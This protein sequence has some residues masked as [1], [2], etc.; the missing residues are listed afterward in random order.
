LLLFSS[1]HFVFKSPIQDRKHYSNI[2]NIVL[3]ILYECDTWSSN[4][5]EGHR[6]SVCE[7]RVQRG[8]FAPNRDGENY[9]VKS[10]KICT[11]HKMLLRQSNL[12]VGWDM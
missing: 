5:R 9:T 2:Q 4:V 11:L 3:I 10:F 7:N 8:T 6:L 1:E 12:G